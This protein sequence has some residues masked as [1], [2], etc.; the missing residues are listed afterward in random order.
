MHNGKQQITTKKFT[1]K[2][3]SA[4]DQGNASTGF[5]QDLRL[6]RTCRQIYDE[7]SSVLYYNNTFV[8]LSPGTFTAYFGL[9]TP[10][11]VY[12]PRSTEPDRM[13]A[14]QAMTEI[15]VCGIVGRRPFL[16]ILSASRLIRT[17]LGC[18][19]SLAS[20]ELS[21]EL[22]GKINLQDWK[23]D[24]C[25]F[26]KPSSLN[27]LVVDVRSSEYNREQRLPGEKNDLDIAEE[28]VHRTLKQEDFTDTVE[29]F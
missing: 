11:Q 25:M 24:D 6:L 4:L 3:E 14:I 17:G 19:T 9:I 8:F 1:P 2:D 28:L 12:V 5:V 26:S 7:A 29:S 20:L 21:L 16:D 13:R 23:I 10:E 15:E 22:Y 18:L 27:K